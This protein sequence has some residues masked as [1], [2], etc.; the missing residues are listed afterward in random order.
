MGQCESDS[1]LKGL[2]RELDGVIKGHA[3][4][5]VQMRRRGVSGSP[6]PVYAPKLQSRAKELPSTPVVLKAMG[7]YILGHLAYL[8][9]K[10][11]EAKQLLTSSIKLLPEDNPRAWN[12]M[13][14]LLFDQS[15][16]LHAMHCFQESTCLSPNPEALRCLSLLQ[17][18]LAAHSPQATTE[19]L[20]S[21]KAALQLDA[22]NAESWYVLGN[23]YLAVY[24]SS[25]KDR[26][27]LALA[28]KAYRKAKVG[29]CLA[30]AHAPRP[31]RPYPPPR[32]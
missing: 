9:G 15:D 22:S 16:Y 32:V 18:K 13:G 27:T 29:T 2:L 19:S 28:V 25:R 11:E 12:T 4:A 1:T 24:F 26:D 3:M 20:A 17:R 23:A 8:Q 14:K 31:R 21:A 6:A 7:M 5:A 30:L 10:P